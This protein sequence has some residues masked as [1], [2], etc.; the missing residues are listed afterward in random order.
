MTGEREESSI[1]A[2]QENAGANRAKASPERQRRRLQGAEAHA[3]DGRKSP[4]DELGS[5]TDSGLAGPQVI[6]IRVVPGEAH[7]D[8][9][10]GHTHEQDH[11]DGEDRQERPAIWE[12][13]AQID[14]A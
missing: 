7:P 5:E 4:Q 6:K 8:L 1:E 14:F 2:G 9:E 12:D 10:A 13:R 3:Q 11:L